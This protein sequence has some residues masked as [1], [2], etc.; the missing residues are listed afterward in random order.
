MFAT[1]VT[2]ESQIIDIDVTGVGS[3][4]HLNHADLQEFRTGIRNLHSQH[5][6]LVQDT[7]RIFDGYQTDMEAM[8]DR[9]TDNAVQLLALKA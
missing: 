7:T 3:Q 4:M 8:R 9:I 2:T 1:G 5:H 6:Q